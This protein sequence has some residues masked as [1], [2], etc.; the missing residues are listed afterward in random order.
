MELESRRVHLVGSTP[1]P[2]DA[3]V[4]QVARVLKRASGDYGADGIDFNPVAVSNSRLSA[5][6]ETARV[7]FWLSAV[8]LIDLHRARLPQTR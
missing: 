1:Y 6:A 5:R 2:N 7:R 4:C 8:E 3:F